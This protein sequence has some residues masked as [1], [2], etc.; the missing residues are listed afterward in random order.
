MRVS[1]VTAMIAGVLLISGRSGL[2]SCGMAPVRAAFATSRG[3]ADLWN[4]F[5]KGKVGVLQRS[6]HQRYLFGAY[7]LLSG[8][9]LTE[10]EANSLYPLPPT[11]G[12]P[13]DGTPGLDG[14]IA[15][16]NAMPGL[17]APT[18]PNPYKEVTQDGL[19]YSFANCHEDAF[20]TASETLAELRAKWGD[21][22]PRTLSWV[23]SQDQVFANCGGKDAVIPA[24]PEENADPLLAAHRRYQIAAAYLYSGQ[25]RKASGAF[26]QI[27]EDMESPWRGFAPYLAARALLRAG[28]LDGDRDAFREGKERLLKILND[29][30]QA[31]WHDASLRLLHL[32]QLKVEPQAR[33][34]ELEKELMRPS[35][36]DVGQ[37]VIDLLYLVNRR[38]DGTG[39]EWSQ[40]EVSEVE[41]TSGLAAWMLAMSPSPPVDAGAQSVESWR[42]TH[43]PAWLIPAIADGPEIDLPE[44]LQAARGIAPDAREYE[45]VVYYA[46]SR[47]MG[48]GHPEEARRWADRALSHD[49]LRSSRNLI[50]AQRIRISRDWNEFLRFSLRRPEMYVVKVEGSDVP[51]ERTSMPTGT[52]PVFDDDAISVFNARAPL[53]LW[54]DAARNPILPAHMQLRIAEAG[55]MRAVVLGRYEEGRKLLG[56][57]VEIRPESAAEA[58]GFLTAREPEEARFAA[59]YAVLRTPSLVPRL[60]IPDIPTPDLAAP[61]YTGETWGFGTG[62]WAQ[63]GPKPEQPLAPVSDFLSAAERTRGETEWKEIRT[64]EPWDAT[65]LAR[66]AVDWALRHPDDRRVPEALHR[67]VLATR[68]RCS[69]PQTGKYSKQAFDLLHRRYPKSEWTARTKYWY[70]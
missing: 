61:R 23:R 57:A 2:D 20:S 13:P 12:V 10:T 59:L 27:A 67:A 40:S 1:R 70:R 52:L 56:R 69:D 36:E 24:L 49:L 15:M 45:S 35:E 5:L 42:K 19:L 17:D 64:A 6:Y 60:A 44:L 55:W 54:A 16:R 31:E 38:M 37:S 32:W 47:E 29:P 11:S 3:P 65:Y 4:Q 48:R 39:R 34:A 22:D 41:A 7:R 50:A 26:Q 9:P 21:D 8:V 66:Q 14:W 18:N 68:W 46:I 62:C 43:N 30:E 28:M 63:V 51:T 25:S 33:L 58:S 53:S